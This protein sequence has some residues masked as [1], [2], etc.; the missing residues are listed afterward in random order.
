MW[1]HLLILQMIINGKG[2]ADTMENPWEIIFKAV[3]IYF[4]YI[5]IRFPR[6]QTL[7]MVCY[8]RAPGQLLKG[9][10]YILLG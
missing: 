4:I 5:I 10:G 1:G 2:V 6:Y 9:S 7:G 3:G 8:N